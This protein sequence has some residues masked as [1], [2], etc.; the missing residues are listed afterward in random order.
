[1]PQTILLVDDEPL[2]CTIV[3][4]LLTKFGYNVLEAKD[5]EEALAVFKEKASGIDLLLTDILMPEMSG[6]ELATKVLELRPEMPVV[7]ISAYCDHLPNAM[8]KFPCVAK[9]FTFHDLVNKVRLSLGE[10]GDQRMKFTVIK[11]QSA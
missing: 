2:V 7:F 1:M 11:R 10:E 9:P 4:T 5:G 8:R 6:P 3:R